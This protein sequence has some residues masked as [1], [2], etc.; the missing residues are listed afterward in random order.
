MKLHNK[1]ILHPTDFS[2]N[3][4]KALKFSL[5]F[6]AIPTTRILIM[7]VIE[8]PPGSKSLQG[9]D[10]VETIDE[11]EAMVMQKIDQYILKC[12][13]KLGIVPVPD[14]EIVQNTLAYK[15]ILDTIKRLDPF[16]VVVGQ[17]GTSGVKDIVMGSTTARLLEKSNCPVITVPYKMDI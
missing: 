17:R 7:H 10:A 13:G 12:F 15:G 14:R 5:E 8:T 2:D 11:K 16:M 3:A 1:I 6:L 9:K 4:A